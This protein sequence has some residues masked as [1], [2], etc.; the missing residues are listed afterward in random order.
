MTPPDPSPEEQP[1]QPP[2]Q[3]EVQSPAGPTWFHR[4]TSILFVIFCFEIGP[5][6]LI[7]SKASQASCEY[8][9][10]G[11]GLGTCLGLRSPTSA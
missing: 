4:L 6:R 2:A 10:R 9:E 3:S 5:A 1:S 7:N 11:L 8:S